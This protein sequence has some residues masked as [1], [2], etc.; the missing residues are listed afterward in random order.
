M[1]TKGG[2]PFGQKDGTCLF[3]VPTDAA[4]DAAQ[5]AALLPTRLLSPSTS[6][7]LTS[8]A[9]QSAAASLSK[10]VVYT[11]A[12]RVSLDLPIRIR[13]ADRAPYRNNRNPKMSP[14]RSR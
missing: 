4:G 8:P 9:M 7:Y 5:D 11:T 6:A 10:A 1:G 2:N 12:P 13:A 3:P 14:L